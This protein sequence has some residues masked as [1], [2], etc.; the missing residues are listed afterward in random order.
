MQSINTSPTSV[1]VLQ[2]CKVLVDVMVF[3]LHHGGIR[4][5]MLGQPP[6]AQPVFAFGLISPA[7]LTHSQFRMRQ[8][9]NA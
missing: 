7:A 8:V 3:V 4:H 9:Y 2:G 5:A 1:L 6:V